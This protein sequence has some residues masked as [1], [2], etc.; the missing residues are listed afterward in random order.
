MLRGI[1]SRA[2]P[3]VVLF[4]STG[5]TGLFLTGDI[6]SFFVFF[7]LSMI[8]SYVLTSTADYPEIRA[9]SCSP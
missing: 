4:M 6:F 1:E 5:L 9:R 2:F 7:E 3:A 8:A